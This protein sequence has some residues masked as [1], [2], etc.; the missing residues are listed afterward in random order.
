MVMCHNATAQQWLNEQNTSPVRFLDIVREHEEKVSAVKAAV[1]EEDMP[2]GVV[3]EGADYQFGRWQWYWKQH[4]DADGYIVSPVR[5]Q[6]EWGK[7]QSAHNNQKLSRT[8]GTL[9]AWVFKGPDT[10][11]RGYGGIGRI[12]VVAFHPTDPN[13]FWIGSPGGGAWMTANSGAT[14]R[15]MTDNLPL[16]SVSDIDINPLNPNTIYLSTGD[17]DA[18]DYYSIGVLV[19]HN[20]GATWDTTDLKW[21]SYNY[22]QCNALVIN[23]LDTNTLIVATSDGIYRSVNAGHTWNRSISG[24]FKEVVYNV[25]DTNV[26]YATSGQIYRSTDGGVTWSARTAFTDVGRTSIAVT[27]ANPAIVK[28]VCASNTGSNSNGLEGFYTSSDSG[29]TFR[30]IYKGACDSNMLG[31]DV[32]GISCGGQGWYDLCIAMSQ[33]D[34]NLVYIGGVNSWYSTNGGSNWGLMTFWYS[35]SSFIGEVA[36]ADK[37]YMAFSPLLPSRL[38]QCND[39]GVYMS[40]NPG[41]TAWSNKLTNGLGITEFYRNAVASDTTYVLGGSQDNGSKML[42]GTGSYDVGGGDGMECQIDPVDPLVYYYTYPNGTIERNDHGI[43]KQ[44]TTSI[45]SPTGAWITPFVIMPSNNKGIVAGFKQLYYSFDGGDVWTMIP[46]TLPTASYDYI[47]HIALTAVDQSTMY[48]TTDYKDTV[49]ATH[50]FGGT[51]SRIP[52]PYH[53]YISGIVADPR[54]TFHFWVTFSGYDTVKAAEYRPVTGWKSISA[55][56]PNVPV[57]CIEI[58]TSTHILYIGTEVGVFYRNDTMTRWQPYNNGLPALRVNDL[59]INYTT[60]TI[61]AATYGRGMWSSPTQTFDT[62][63]HLGISIIPYATNAVIIA[64][65]PN[66]GNFT[67]SCAGLANADVQIDVIDIIGRTIWHTSG[68]L[69]NAGKTSV[70]PGSILTKG[71]YL[72]QITG[73]KGIAG[74]QKLVVY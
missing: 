64:P 73:N 2:K 33:R 20:G 35:G 56:L 11:T 36:H 58:D 14:W 39:G 21:N 45:G 48:V 10:T 49:Y 72:L 43:L 28:A 31:Y 63:R 44:V 59:G 61:W 3:K 5:T 66:R 4:L 29:K 34:S 55:S 41:T 8:T 7:Y 17:R 60:G 46:D 16:L 25:S 53:D 26:L 37:H 47:Q 68:H 27:K 62:N 57:A 42:T 70:A 69:D 50:T 9:D 13:T 71:N 54:D 1:Q 30:R 22:R 19:S 15:S 74:R 6:E 23:P 67:V 32:N 18:G 38:F 52:V 51:W 40:D 12:N 24:N 65:N